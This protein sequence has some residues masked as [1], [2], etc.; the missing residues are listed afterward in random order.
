MNEQNQKTVDQ[1]EEWLKQMRVEIKMART[2]KDT[3]V[4]VRI[5]RYIA[6]GVLI[7]D[8]IKAVQEQSEV[9][10]KYFKL[11]GQSIANQH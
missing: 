11:Y 2:V 10:K 5:E 3:N 8:L 9:A 4:T 1:A 7:S 6:N